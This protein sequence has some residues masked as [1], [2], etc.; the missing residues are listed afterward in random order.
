MLRIFLH[1]LVIALASAMKFETT[2]RN[3]PCE[4]TPFCARHRFFES[5][6][7]RG[8]ASDMYYSID[9]T[10]VVIHDDKG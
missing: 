2:Y 4:E 10:S 8:A 6:K 1:V 3:P 9:P 5:E 7:L